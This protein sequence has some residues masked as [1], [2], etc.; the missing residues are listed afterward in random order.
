[1]LWQK[2]PVLTYRKLGVH[3]KCSHCVTHYRWDIVTL[4][5]RAT[6][7]STR[8]FLAW[9]GE[10]W[11]FG[12]LEPIDVSGI[13]QARRQSYPS[14]ISLSGGMLSSSAIHG[15]VDVELWK[16]GIWRCYWRLQRNYRMASNDGSNFHWEV[17]GLPHGVISEISDN[18]KSETVQLLFH[19]LKVLSKRLQL[20]P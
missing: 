14:W 17:L 2:V 9:K 12:C 4:C 10:G 6:S 16:R 15:T 3:F 18:C 8:W 19:S 7:S 13:S 11:R 5:H 1:M 20:S